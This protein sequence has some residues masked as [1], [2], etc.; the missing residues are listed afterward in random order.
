[1]NCKTRV[2]QAAGKL[3][4]TSGCALLGGI[5]WVV[6]PVL[7]AKGSFFR[8]AIEQLFLFAPLVVVPLAFGVAERLV[9]SEDESW[10][11]R[12]PRCLQPFGAAAAVASFA[13]AP[14]RLA[15]LVAL[16]WFIVTGS[17]A[18]CATKRLRRRGLGSLAESCLD[19]AFLYLPIGGAWLVLSRAGMTPIGFKEPIVLLTAV[20][21]HYSAF[22]APILV[23]AFA[24]AT[25]NPSRGRSAALRAVAAGVIIAPGLLALGFVVS[26]GLK[27]LSAF[28]LTI[29]LG[30]LAILTLGSLP[31]IERRLA[32][33]LLAVSA[34]SVLAGMSLASV[35][36]VG[37][38]LG[39]ELISI[40]L[41]ARLHGVIN[42][43]GFALCGFISWT[44]AQPGNCFRASDRG[45][46]SRARTSAFNPKPI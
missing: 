40:P 21:F 23:G 30:G 35:Y 2:S 22:A 27:V 39:R 6:L 36:A 8:G 16:G 33:V 26:P 1:M 43:F 3:D 19:A 25:G 24:R 46:A 15:A 10:L 31:L 38:F 44:V 32:R 37:D 20:H 7:S 18:L 12:L 13:L 42:S 9:S 28:L 45:D 11:H 17:T 4:W 14:G 29:S 5:G 34:G 41:M